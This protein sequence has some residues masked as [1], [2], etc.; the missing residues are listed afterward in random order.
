MCFM[1]EVLFLELP[2]GR[3]V[4]IAVAEVVA[5]FENGAHFDTGESEDLAGKLERIAV[6]CH[7][8]EGR[9]VFGLDGEGNDGSIG[10]DGASFDVG[11]LAIAAEVGKLNGGGLLAFLLKHFDAGVV[12]L[13]VQR[14]VGDLLE[15]EIDGGG[16][17]G[18]GVVGHLELVGRGLVELGGHEGGSDED[19]NQ[20]RRQA[21]ATDSHGFFLCF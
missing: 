17:G 13:I 19:E 15:I 14:V 7:S 18:F 8:R 16:A 5:V 2:E 20:E 3:R 12:A 11:D 6:V 10:V 1:D 4:P 21:E 9:Q